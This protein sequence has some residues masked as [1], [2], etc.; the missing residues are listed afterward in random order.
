MV[1]SVGEQTDLSAFRDVPEHIFL[2]PRVDQLAVLARAGVFVTHC[3][4]NS[5]SEG[6]YFGVPLVLYPQ[7]AEQGLVARRVEE[8]GAG[9]RLKRPAPEAI[10][11]A[12]RQV[13]EQ[14]S[15]RSRAREISAG[16]REAGGYRRGA[17]KILEAAAR[18]RGTC[19]EY[20]PML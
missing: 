11:A 10:R 7:Q 14:Q 16:F 13:R 9:L 2:R 20:T 17:D 15:Y 5:A 19:A 4:M 3:G 1:I 8:L 12:V 18:G 6:L